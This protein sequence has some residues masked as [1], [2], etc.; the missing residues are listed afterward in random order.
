MFRDAASQERRQNALEQ[1]ERTME[2]PLLILAVA[3]I[4]LLVLPLL[5]DLPES[6]D[7][8]F[9]AL[10]WFIWAAF[11][12]EYFVRFTLTN[13]RWRFVRREWADLLIVVLPFLRPLRVVRSARALRLVRLTRLTAI[14]GVISKE[15][16]RLIHRHHLHQVL[17][18][19]AAGVLVAAGLVT[20][21]E[22]GRDSNIHDFGDGLWWAITTITTVGYGDTFPRTDAGRGIAAVVMVAGITLFGLVTANIAAF[23]LER[24]SEHQEEV[25]VSIEAKLDLLLDRLA[26]LEAGV[27][28]M[29]ADLGKTGSPTA[30]S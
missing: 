22:D 26:A 12:F 6:V 29:R 27:E 11:A 7:T 13:K 14:I 2:L 5:A 28:S 17:L 4:P 9:I 20:I 25:E 19:A 1:F 3:M 18:I 8:A 24:T 10:D 30:A 15:T 21:L 23:I 16:R